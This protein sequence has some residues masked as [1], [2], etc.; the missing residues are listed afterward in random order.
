VKQLIERERKKNARLDLILSI[1][2]WLDSWGFPWSHM[3]GRL[4]R[5]HTS[6]HHQRTN[7]AANGRWSYF[8]I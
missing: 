2:N 8:F 3:S 6:K 1:G 4:S 7:V 5:S